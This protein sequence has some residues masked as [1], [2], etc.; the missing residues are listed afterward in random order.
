[1]AKGIRGGLAI[2]V[3]GV[4]ALDRDIR[5]AALL[6]LGNLA[7]AGLQ[8]LDPILFGKVVGMLPDTG[9]TSS[10]AWAST[11]A[12]WA[13]VGIFSV[14]LG[15]AIGLLSDRMANRNRLRIMREYHASALSLPSSYHGQNHS[16]KVM[17]TMW[18]GMDS[19]FGLWLGLFREQLSNV[20]ALV[21]MLPLTV[22]INPMLGGV[23]LVLLVIFTGMTVF[24]VSKTERLQRST[25]TYHGELAATAQDAMGNVAVVQA[26]GR[27][28]HE[29]DIMGRLSELVSAHQLPVLGWWAAT[30]MATRACSTLA[31]LSIVAV[32]GMLHA[33]GRA[34]VADVIAFMGFAGIVIGRMESLVHFVSRQVSSRASLEDFFGVMDARSPISDD[35]QALCLEA[36]PATVEFEN[37]GF[38]YPAGP[39]VLRGV[40]LRA[41]PGSCIALVGKTGAGKTTTM[42]LLRREWD[43]TSGVV[44]VDGQDV[45]SIRLDSLRA[46]VGVVFQDSLMFNR[47]IRDNLLVGKPNATQE[48]LE[49]ACHKAEAH[50]FIM[51]Q[52]KGYDTLIGER[53]TTLSGGQKQRLSIARA[54]LKDAPILI[55]DEATSA[56]DS[57]TEAKVTRALAVLMEGRTTFIIA[58]RLSTIRHADQILVFDEGAVVEQGTFE[59]LVDKNGVFAT[60][61]HSQIVPPP[62]SR[63]LTPKSTEVLET[64][65]TSKIQNWNY[66]DAMTV[67]A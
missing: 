4:R 28:P 27:I 39:Q 3:R 60:L 7:V 14:G 49:T 53:G 48:D 38:H 55:L 13:V 43:A 15:L 11:L 6:G 17:R 56:L 2:Y 23:L 18:A 26:F 35:E 9:S 59:E 44:R 62:S 20:A 16:G 22:F 31:V 47:T 50:D 58:H 40:S 5:L 67:D 25:E 12:L 29:S 64:A 21:V 19:C 52:E 54:L 65:K 61:V 41:M 8:F 36:G 45:R 63:A 30:G 57:A 1:M 33:Q 34:S 32:G 66:G 24:V 46:K 37:V 42:S 10:S 51:R